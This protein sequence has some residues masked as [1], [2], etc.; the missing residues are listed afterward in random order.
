MSKS[1]HGDRLEFNILKAARSSCKKINTWPLAQLAKFR[2]DNVG[3]VAIV[4]ALSLMTLISIT[5]GAIDYARW[6]SARSKTVNAMDAA[7][8]AGGR[9]LQLSGMT[10]SDAIA[11]AQKYYS[12]N[13]SDVL[14]VDTTTFTATSTAVVGTTASTVKTAFLSLLSMDALPVNATV[15]AEISTGGNSGSDVEIS[16]M[17]DTTGSMSGSKMVDLKL[18]AKDLVDIVVWEDQSQFTSK[19]AIALFSRYVNVS[20]TYFNAVT[21]ATVGGAIDERTCVK[22]RSTSDRYTDAPPSSG[23]Y[24]NYYGGSGTCDP[25]ATIMPLSNNKTTLKNH[26]DTLPTTGMTAGHLGT[27]WAWYLI[28]PRWNNIWPTGSQPKS[29]S[30]INVDNGYGKPKLYKIAILMTDGAYNKYYSGS[31]STTQARAV[32]DE[33]KGSD[34]TV[35]TVGFAIAVIV[36]QI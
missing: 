11:A 36:L 3:A 17:L 7:I 21:G 34:V 19:V 9:V 30:L 31:D 25:T 26:I 23:N 29:Y 35:Y 2:R 24:F 13:K 10:T 33:M 12:E 27:A 22:E 5:G 4:F 6:Q 32:C 8:L 28:S 14:Y 16:M 18:A 20:T 1:V 15:K